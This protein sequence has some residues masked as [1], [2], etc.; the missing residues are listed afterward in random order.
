MSDCAST[1][2]M[3]GSDS[4]LLEALRLAAVSQTWDF[5]PQDLANTTWAFVP[6]EERAEPVLKEE[7]PRRR[8]AFAVGGGVVRLEDHE[9]LTL[10]EE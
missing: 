1:L 4:E 8:D 9:E 7:H 10:Q 5:N 6:L 3:D 2:R